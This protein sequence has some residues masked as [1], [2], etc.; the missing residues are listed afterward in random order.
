MTLHPQTHGLVDALKKLL[1]ARGATYRDLAKALHLSEPSIKRLFSER[2]LT[3]TRIEEICAFLEVDFFDLAKL[4]RGVAATVNEMSVEQEKALARDSRLLGV[5]YLVFNEW[6]IEEIVSHYVLTRAEALKLLLQLD[7]LGLADL[8]PGD[9]VR[10]RVPKGLRLRL[11]GP[12]RRLHGPSVVSSFLEA[13]FARQGG[14][15]R[16]EFRELSQASFALVQRRLERMAA[17]FNELAELDSYLPSA[18]R[19][20]IGMALGV[21]PWIMS[22]V[23]GLKPRGAAAAK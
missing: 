13:D 4:A 7:H 6:K 5:F 12:I 2:T 1:K 23:T 19:E 3:L 20:T 22:W 21:R 10:L 15:F 16:F 11:D 8:L 18:Q 14:L 17:D 9:K